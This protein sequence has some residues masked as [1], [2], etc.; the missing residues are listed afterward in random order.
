MLVNKQNKTELFSKKDT[1]SNKH[2][3]SF[4]K[5]LENHLL[6]KLNNAWACYEI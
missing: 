5:I 6:A 3:V 1:R 4:S 2:Y